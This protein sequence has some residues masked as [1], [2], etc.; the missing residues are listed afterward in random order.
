MIALSAFSVGAAVANTWAILY[1]LSTAA[2]VFTKPNPQPV[3]TVFDPASEPRSKVGRSNS[4]SATVCPDQQTY[5]GEYRN[6]IYG[7]S[8]IIPRGLKG[9]WNSARCAPDEEYGCVCMGDHGRFIPLSD[10]AYVEAFVGY[11]MEEGWSVK[12]YENQEVADLKVEQ[13]V[14]QVRVVSSRWVR[15]GD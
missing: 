6:L 3:T 11:E 13:G 4:S 1:P 15:L 2:M 5:T 12:D 14:G 9:Y 10:D 7:F 8:I